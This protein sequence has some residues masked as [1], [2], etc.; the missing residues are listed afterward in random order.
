MTARERT[1]RGAR[2]DLYA[3]VFVVASLVA[4]GLLAWFAWRA[5][6]EPPDRHLVRFLAL[7]KE[8]EDVPAYQLTTTRFR[9]SVPLGDFVER[10]ST[11]AGLRT[12]TLVRVEQYRALSFQPQ[13]SGEVDIC[14]YLEDP[15]AP[16]GTRRVRAHL[17]EEDGEW[18][19]DGLAV[20]GDQLDPSA[21]VLRAACPPT[22]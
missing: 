19:L 2:R 6:E 8:Y 3:R 20:E 22:F 13:P 18:R 4:A 17:V 15:T 21:R 9:A 12:T 11:I 10:L 16:G 5:Q 7:T 1:K 14:R